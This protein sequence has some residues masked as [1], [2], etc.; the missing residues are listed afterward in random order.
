MRALLK[1]QRCWSI[2]HITMFATFW[3]KFIALTIS[4]NSRSMAL[5]A[6]AEVP[7]SEPIHCCT[8][9]ATLIIKHSGGSPP[10]LASGSAWSPGCALPAGHP[11]HTA[12]APAT[13]LEDEG[14][15]HVCPG[16][17]SWL[18]Q[19]LQRERHAQ[20]KSNKQ[21]RDTRHPTAKCRKA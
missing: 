14:S 10:P 5:A 20:T 11:P 9:V 15:L 4:L 1:P 7:V 2:A 8:H 19:G 21:N 17:A 18:M 3:Q 12:A 13:A 16:K 6:L